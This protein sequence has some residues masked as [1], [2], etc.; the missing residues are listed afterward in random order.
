VS[1]ARPR[2]LENGQGKWDLEAAAAEHALAHE[3]ENAPFPFTYKGH[4]YEIPPM[5]RWPVGAL[6]AVAQGD[7]DSALVDLLGMETYES[8]ID[9]G[10]IV[11]ELT[12]LFD[13][14]AADSGMGGAGNSPPPR[15]PSSIPR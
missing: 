14:I 11:G 4:D 1:P 10:L 3:A 8:L 9:A 7:L 12:V 2:E 13:K 15:R 6:R 5:A